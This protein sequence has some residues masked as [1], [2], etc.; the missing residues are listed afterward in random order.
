V[1]ANLPPTNKKQQKDIFLVMGRLALKKPTIIAPGARILVRDA[2]RI[3][4]RVD[5]TSTGGQVFAVT[6]LS[7]YK[8]ILIPMGGEN[9]H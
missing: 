5:S 6:G 8:K 7:F 3:V 2:E 9:E 4:R 1:G